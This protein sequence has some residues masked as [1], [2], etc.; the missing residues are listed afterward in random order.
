[1]TPFRRVAVGTI[2][3]TAYESSVPVWPDG[4]YPH[5]IGISFHAVGDAISLSDVGAEN[6]EAIRY[7]GS[8]SGAPYVTSTAWQIPRFAEIVGG[9][10]GKS[11]DGPSSEAAL[12]SL[13]EA[14]SIRF[15]LTTSSIEKSQ[16]R[17]ESR[18]AT[19][20]SSS[21]VTQKRED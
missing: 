19:F 5:R 20:D 1:M 4:S 17:S 15:L 14:T 16:Q 7:S 3:K 9:L 13:D 21:S 6:W 12:A 10:A 11:L 2:V 18:L 8:A